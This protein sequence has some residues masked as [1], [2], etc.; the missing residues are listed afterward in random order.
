MNAKTNFACAMDPDDVKIL[1]DKR[2]EMGLSWERFWHHVIELIKP[3]RDVEDLINLKN[4]VQE[5][6]KDND[7][8]KDPGRSRQ[9]PFFR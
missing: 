5:S 4:A 3:V 7:K 9:S 1:R 6:E 8:H 2:K